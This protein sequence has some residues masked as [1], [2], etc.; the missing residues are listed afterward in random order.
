MNDNTI[1][2]TDPPIE[3]IKSEENIM[4]NETNNAKQ[5]G[6]AANGEIDKLAFARELTEKLM[7]CNDAVRGGYLQGLI[8]E[9]INPPKLSREEFK[10]KA[11]EMLFENPPDDSSDAIRAILEY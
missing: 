11:L 3:K 8:S 4:D 9:L 5:C 7:Q 1:C 6:N 2:L 10:L